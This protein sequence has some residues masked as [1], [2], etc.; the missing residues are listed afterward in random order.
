MHNQYEINKKIERLKSSQT[1]D[2]KYQL[3]WGWIKDSSL[4]FRGFK[5]IMNELQKGNDDG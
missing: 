3:V 4:S 5:K 1:L 2:D